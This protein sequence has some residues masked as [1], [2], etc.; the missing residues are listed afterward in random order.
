MA[1]D[2]NYTVEMMAVSVAFIA[3]AAQELK[4][5]KE[6]SVFID[7]VKQKLN[8]IQVIHFTCR[9]LIDTTNI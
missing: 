7:L 3:N 5:H 8:F 2:T 1:I 9:Y 4:C 6:N